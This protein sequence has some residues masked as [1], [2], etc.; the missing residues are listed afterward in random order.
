MQDKP[1]Y[2]DITVP[3]WLEP[4]PRDLALRIWPYVSLM[5]LDR[6]IGTWLL[7][8]PGWWAIAMAAGGVMQMGLREWGMMALFGVGALVMRGAG[9]VVN[10][11]WDRDL[12]AQVERTATRPLASGAIS[13]RAA[14]VFLAGLCA[15]GL[16]ILLSLPK[17]AIMLG[18]LSVPF[19]VAYP[20][21]KRWTWWPQMFLGLT[22]NF[23]ALIGWAA[24]ADA[25]AWPALLLYAGGIFWTLGYD[26]IYA[27]QDMDDDALIGVRSTTRLF[28]AQGP[29]WV[30]GFYAAAIALW[31]VAGWAVDEATGAA[32]AN[33]AGAGYWIGLAAVA[34]HFV[35]QVRTWEMHDRAGSLRLFRSNRD[36][37]FLM[38]LA[39]GLFAL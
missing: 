9:C 20:L 27:A 33:L 22:F 25:L 38:A 23:G 29:R 14:L 1:A 3:R 2:T 36:A 39:C 7:L 21:M 19:I 18:F 8:L 13:M 28:G 26:T 11:M 30:G 16:G 15:I 32:N 35:W 12:D 4:L 37:A 5:R 6:P 17:T 24:V 10:D 34:A 31:A